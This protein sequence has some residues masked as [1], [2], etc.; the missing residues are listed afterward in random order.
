MIRVLFSQSALSVLS[1]GC[2]YGLSIQPLPTDVGVIWRGCFLLV[3]SAFSAGSILSQPDVLRAY[4]ALSL[5]LPVLTFY[6]L[7]LPREE[8]GISLVLDFS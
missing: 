3:N 6:L 2:T 1:G 5:A 7:L 8:S 4:L